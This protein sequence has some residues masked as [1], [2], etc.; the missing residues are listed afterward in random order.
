VITDYRHYATGFCQNSAPT[1]VTPRPPKHSIAEKLTMYFKGYSALLLLTV[2]VVCFFTFKN[3]AVCPGRYAVAQLAET[4]HYKEE[5]RGFGS[6]WHYSP[7]VDSAFNRNVY[8]WYVMGSKGDRCLGLTT[9]PPSCT[10][11]QEILRV[12]T[13]WSPKG[14]SRPAM[15]QLYL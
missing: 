2:T 8:Q 10:D 6:Q 1:G 5:G 12:L 3:S 7:G 15:E 4:L 13:S 14:V 11:C 9:L